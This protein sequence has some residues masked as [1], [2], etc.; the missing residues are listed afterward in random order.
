MKPVLKTETLPFLVESR[1]KAAKAFSQRLSFLE[2]FDLFLCL[3][4]L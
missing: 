1:P 4:L 3:L 2:S